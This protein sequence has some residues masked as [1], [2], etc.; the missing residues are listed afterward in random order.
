MANNKE[1]IG[2]IGSGLIGANSGGA[3]LCARPSVP[4]S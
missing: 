2:V 4:G 3:A 1:T